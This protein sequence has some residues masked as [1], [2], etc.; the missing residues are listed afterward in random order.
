MSNS[1]KVALLKTKKEIIEQVEKGKLAV[2][3]AAHLLGITR[4]G[5]WKLRRNYRNHGLQ[6]LIGRKRG[7]QPGCLIHN[8]T[9]EWVEEKLESVYLKYPVGPDRLLWIIKDYYHDELGLLELSRS[10]IYRILV[11]RRLIRPRNKEAKVHTKRY[12]KGY[13]GE[14][15]QLDTTE[16]FGKSKGT[17][18]TIVDDYSR[19][20]AAFIYPG[21]KSQ[22]TATC[23][24]WYLKTAP[25]PVQAV[26]VDNGGEFKK[27]FARFCKKEGIKI[28]RNKPETPEHNGK[29]ERLHRTI[30]EE[31]LWRLTQFT[32]IN[33][34]DP[35]ALNYELAKYINWYNSQRRH[36]GYGMD[37]K[38]PQQAV[39]EWI[40]NN[41]PSIEFSRE[42]NETLI[43]YILDINLL[44]F[45]KI[46]D[47]SK[48]K[49]ETTTQTPPET[50]AQKFRRIL[51][52][53][54][55]PSKQS[56]TKK[57][58]LADYEGRPVLGLERM[59]SGPG[60]ISATSHA[61]V[62]G[63]SRSK[64][65]RKKQKR[66]SYTRKVDARLGET[67]TPWSHRTPR[68]HEKRPGQ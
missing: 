24:S 6:A 60:G 13:P 3:T 49:V 46:L 52:G 62:E 11:R 7:P 12:I 64:K 10:T 56:S 35:E 51:K 63:T 53:E 4:Q 66:S 1:T 45:G 34:Q 58:S 38:T 48:D 21:N 2:Q 26:R 54:T 36:L 67:K 31:C 43:L 19:W 22:D 18:L 16:P 40:I 61:D 8:R 25:F 17:Q 50:G 23:F 27:D 9:P 41:Q 47:M 20:A 55:L 14:E 44:N 30:E 65:G 37:G 68:P 42:V 33:V 39:E 59:L 57:D 29:V 5:L 32:D 15:V 28:I